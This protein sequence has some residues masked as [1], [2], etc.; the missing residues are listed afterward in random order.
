MLPFGFGIFLSTKI[1][2]QKKPP[3][4]PKHAMYS[5]VRKLTNKNDLEK[6]TQVELQ[7]VTSGRKDV[8]RSMVKGD[9]RLWFIS[10]ERGMA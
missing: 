9:L 6:Y 1:I 4:K 2:H 3:K 10:F 8:W 7:V 5:Y